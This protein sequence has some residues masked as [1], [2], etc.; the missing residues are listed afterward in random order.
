MRLQSSLDLVRDGMSAA[1]Y[2]RYERTLRNIVLTIPVEVMNPLSV[3]HPD[4]LPIEMTHLGRNR[5]Q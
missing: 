2:E 4:L 5:P 3:E 1:E